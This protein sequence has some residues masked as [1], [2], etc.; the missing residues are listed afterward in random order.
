MKRFVLIALIAM[1]AAPEVFA[2][3]QKGHDVVAYVA[4]CHLSRRAAK[5]VTKAL[6]GHSP[7]YYA[8]WMDNASHTSEYAYTSTW[9]YAN[10]DE[11][12][13]YETM[14]RNESGDVVTALNDIIEDLRSGE[15]TAEEENTALRMLI[16]LMGDLHCPMHA[17]H[18]S[19]LGGNKVEVSFFGEK[20]RLHTIWD[21]HLVEAAHKWG[22]TEWQR[23]I[24]RLSKEDREDI[25]EGS[26]E[27]WFAETV[28]ICGRVY[29]EIPAGKNI[30]YDE[31]AR[32]AP[33]IEEQLLKGGLRL[34]AVLNSIYR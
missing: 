3:G 30:S 10:V 29:E 4:E 15:L 23:Q 11:G 5:R 8:N 34:A 7:V 21:T 28:E 31:V 17:G 14:P 27:D 33:V 18:K 20:T 12:F 22:Y 16:H 24:D 26:L 13:T 1:C 9:H 32:Y 6:E 19:D 2:W 25:C